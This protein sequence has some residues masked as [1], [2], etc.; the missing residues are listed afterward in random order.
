MKNTTHTQVYLK[1]VFIC[2]E[3]LRVLSSPC[4][5]CVLQ[6]SLRVSSSS[7]LSQTEASQWWTASPVPASHWSALTRSRPLIGWG[8]PWSLMLG[9]LGR[10]VPLT[11]IVKARPCGLSLARPGETQLRVSSWLRPDSPVS[12]SQCVTAQPTHISKLESAKIPKIL[13]TK[14]LS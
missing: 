12:L 9:R 3:W 10:L 4:L 8:G 1:D 7:S 6:P 14:D 13:Q 11:H 2:G 5:S